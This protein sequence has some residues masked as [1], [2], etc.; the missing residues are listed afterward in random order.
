M[1]TALQQRVSLISCVL[2][3]IVWWIN[4]IREKIFSVI[5]QFKTFEL[6]LMLYGFDKGT[7]LDTGLSE[8]AQNT[9]ASKV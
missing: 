1:E 2:S 7:A 9:M 8:M 5:C 3:M 4:K 6:N